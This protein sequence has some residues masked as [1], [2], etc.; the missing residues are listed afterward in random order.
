MQ[1][2]I[3]RYGSVFF[4]GDTFADLR[5]LPTTQIADGFSAI[6][7][8][9]IAPADG[10]GGMYCWN[11]T[12]TAPDDNQFTI[13][14]LDGQRGR[15][16][17]IAVGQVGPVS[18]TPGPIGPPGG[19]VMAIGSFATAAS[20]TIPAGAN[21]VQTSGYSVNGT[22]FAQYVYD[23]T[24]NAAFVAAYPRASFVTANGLGYRLAALQVTPEQFGAVGDGVSNDQPAI[25]AALDYCAKAGITRIVFTQPAYAIWA[26]PR[27]SPL[28]A[29]FAR[30]GHPLV[31]TSTMA[32]VSALQNTDLVF[33]GLN[34]SDPETTGFSVI[35]E[36][37]GDATA[38]TLW[39]GGGVFMLGDVG[40]STP[41]SIKSFHVENMSWLGQRKR[42]V[43]RTN[44]D[45]GYPA[46]PSDPV[47]HWDLTDKGFWN[48]DTA[49][50]PVTGKNWNII[51]FKGEVFYIGGYGPPKII[52]E[53]CQISTTNGDAFNPGGTG[54]YEL[55]NCTIGDSFQCIEGLSGASGAKLTNTKFYDSVQAFLVGAPG[56]S[57]FLY[58]Y[59]FAH[60]DPTKDMPWV[61]MNGVTF[62]NVGYVNLGSY[63]RGT[64]SAT[65]SPIGFV[66]GGGSLTDV[67]VDILSILDN[68]L[69][70]STAVSI[71]GP[72]NFTTTFSGAPANTYVLPPANIN[73]RLRTKHTAN[74]ISKGLYWLHD[75]EGYGIVDVNS[76]SVI[77]EDSHAKLPAR[78]TQSPDHMG[79]IQIRRF[80][81]LTPAN[82]ATSD[83]LSCTSA[84]SG[85]DPNTTYGVNL[86][87]TLR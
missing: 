18:T 84:N 37:A 28:S 26:T 14:P 60:R 36:N 68:G 86:V 7:K 49:I 51:G 11:A 85:T 76:V 6:V 74:A 80:Q 4:N 73:I 23:P 45:Q 69:D 87:S 10:L 43:T 33:Y 2:N 47:H 20:L 24:V 67:D 15:W 52:L 57:Q 3:P 66:I 27:T 25:Q 82:G 59:A 55:I 61:E 38:A 53:N 31:V 35:K 12:S 54:H 32:M 40:T 62:E 58:N 79:Y 48:Q 77:I 42:T 8:G 21:L 64:I 56:N 30:D 65:D 44:G 13:A 81:S 29:E 16:L 19:N 63:I 75:F 78:W 83:Y 9:G 39:R 50:G 41:T 5:S 17:R 34:G 70:G 1:I 22:G 71:G 72:S 46:V